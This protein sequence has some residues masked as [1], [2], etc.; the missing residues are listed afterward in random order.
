ME[1]RGKI[2]FSHHH[3]K[4]LG[5]GEE[6]KNFGEVTIP[7]PPLFKGGGLVVFGL[8]RFC[9]PSKPHKKME[10]GEG[11]EGGVL[12]AVEA[13]IH[14]GRRLSFGVVHLVVVLLL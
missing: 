5:R 11:G 13:S 2:S 1:P 9:N 10:Q 8:I 4:G 14:C 3:P 7:D 12:K 6:T